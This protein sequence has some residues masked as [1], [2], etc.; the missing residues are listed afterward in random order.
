MPLCADFL[1]GLNVALNVH[2]CPLPT[3][4]GM[5]TSLNGGTC[6]V[7]LDLANKYFQMEVSYKLQ[8]PLTINTHRVLCQ[9]TRLSF[10]VKTATAI[11]S[12]WIEHYSVGP[13]GSFSIS[14]RNNT[15]V[16]LGR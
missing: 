2:C 11:N 10:G 1:T 16:K 9:Y 5:F 8:K 14:Q 4:E 12:T 13:S 3:P 6:F 15:V 7:E